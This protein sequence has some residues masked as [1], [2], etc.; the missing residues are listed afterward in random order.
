MSHVDKELAKT[1]RKKGK[2]YELSCVVRNALEHG[3]MISIRPDRTLYSTALNI[4]TGARATSKQCGDSQPSSL[5]GRLRVERTS[6]RSVTAAFSSRA[7]FGLRSHRAPQSHM[8][9]CMDTLGHTWL[10]RDTL[11][12]IWLYRGIRGP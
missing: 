4:L 12:H 3:R 1:S 10:C 11:G 9:L 8:W 6:S 5:L 2:V 7:V